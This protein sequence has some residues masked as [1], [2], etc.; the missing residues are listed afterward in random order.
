[1]IQ[2]LINVNQNGLMINGGS[3]S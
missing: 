3:Y 1:M 2:Y